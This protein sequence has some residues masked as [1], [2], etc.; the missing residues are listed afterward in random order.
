MD[1]ELKGYIIEIIII[2]NI[3]NIIISFIIFYK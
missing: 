1:K 3:M 2:L